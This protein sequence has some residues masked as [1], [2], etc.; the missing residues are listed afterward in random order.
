[1]ADAWINLEYGK[2]STTVQFNN[3]SVED[4]MVSPEMVESD[5]ADFRKKTHEKM[6]KAFDALWEMNK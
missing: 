3:D 6:D 1:M 2:A 4:E 5:F